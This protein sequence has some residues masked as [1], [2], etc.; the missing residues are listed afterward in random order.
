[1]GDSPQFAV[2]VQRLEVWFTTARASRAGGPCGRSCGSRYSPHPTFPRPA[3]APPSR[4]GQWGCLRPPS[5]KR[6][7]R[8]RCFPSHGKIRRRQA[9]G[10][11]TWKSADA[12]CRPKCSCT[13]SHL[14]PGAR[15]QADLTQ[16]QG[17]LTRQQGELTDVK[18]FDNVILQETQTAQP[19]D[20]PLLVTGQWLH[21]TEANSPHAKVTVTGGRPISKAAA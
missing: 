3:W 1:M 20:K 5:L 16:Q 9:A 6:L 8:R 21:A 14:T 17:E 11:P 18:V 4:Q 19:S 7:L 12:C 2:K 10:R 15:P 13:T